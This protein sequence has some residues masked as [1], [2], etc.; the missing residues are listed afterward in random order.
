MAANFVNLTPHVINVLS[1]GEEVMNLPP[2]GDVARVAAEKRKVDSIDGV[3]VFQTTFGS[4]EGL[5]APQDGTIYVVSLLVASA[6]KRPDVL[7]PGTLVRDAK[8]NP[9]GCD[10]LAS[11]V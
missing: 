2:S 8:G 4:I 7:S 6:A 11:H 1:D 10:G 3:P 5:P 9:V